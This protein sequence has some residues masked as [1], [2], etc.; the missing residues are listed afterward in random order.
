MGNTAKLIFGGILSVC[1]PILFFATYFTVDA[2]ERTVVTRFGAV[3]AVADAGL[4]FKMPFV[5]ETHAFRTD[6]QSIKPKEAA[7]TYTIDNQEVDVIFNVFYRI[8]ADKVVFIYTNVPDFQARLLVLAND[9]LKAEMGRVNVAHVAEKRGELRDKIK[10]VLVREAG[11]L[12]IEITDFQLANLEYTKSFKAAV[13]QAASAKAG[14]ET[15]EQEKQQAMKSAETA[16][17]NAEGKAN[18]IRAVAKGQADANLLVAQAAAK[19]IQLK[20][21]AEAAA[22][23]A[24]ADALK[25]NVNLVELRKAERWNGELPKTMLSNVVPFMNVDQAA[26]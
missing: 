15:R 6:I 13:E 4:H 26:K 14:V 2:Y 18:A 5:N 24:Q 10:S 12:G 16:A 1:A 25:Q 7:N 20:G 8:P 9:R 11:A 17:I 22:I 21:E 23:R 19:A 3:V